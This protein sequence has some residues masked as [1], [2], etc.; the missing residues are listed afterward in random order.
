MIDC[1]AH[2]GEFAENMDDVIERAKENGVIGVVMVPEYQSSQG[3]D[4][5]FQFSNVNF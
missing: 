3:R 5:I 2:L 1:H 4:Q